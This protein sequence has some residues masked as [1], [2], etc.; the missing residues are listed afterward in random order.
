MNVLR[1]TWPETGLLGN[2][3][4]EFNKIAR[5]EDARITNS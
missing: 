3:G 4:R 2:I 1:D 5:M